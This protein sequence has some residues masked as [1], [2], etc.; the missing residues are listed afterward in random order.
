MALNYVWVA[1]FLIAFAIGL[2]KFLFFGDNEV[3]GL[4]VQS[5]FDMAKV[6]VEIAVYLIGVISL[7][8]G[9]MKVGEQGGAVKLLTKLV[10]PFFKRLFPAVPKD[11]PAVGAMMMN[12]SA[13]MLGLDNA[14]TPLGLK[15]MTELQDLNEDKEKASD[16]MIMFIVLNTSGL[17]VVPVSVMAIRA[18]Q[19]AVNPSDIF[20]PVLLATYF[21]TLGGLV[22]V[23][24]KQ[25]I[26]LLQPVLLSWLVGITAGIAGLLYL[27]NGLE[28]DQINTISNLAGNGI[29][30]GL[31]IGFFSL[32]LFKG[33]NVYETFIE[34]AK[35]GFS[36]S[37]KIIPYLVAMLV[38][39]GL[40]RASGSLDYLVGA[41]GWFFGLFL[42]DV[43]FVDALPTALMKPLSGSGAR[44][45][46]VEQMN[47][48]GADSFVGRLASVFQ[49]STETTF[50]TLA[51]YFG[52]ISIKKTRYA[53]GA[54]LF[55][56]LCGI[57]AAI[58][59]S[60]IFFG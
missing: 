22:A 13:N 34:G 46:M 47:T 33:I 51:V 23:S 36:V 54:G 15:A 44:G 5:T 56:D 20:L 31:I 9:I 19:G 52:A 49:G 39:I 45:M 38:A 53:L 7:W 27:L 28:Q 6:S 43:R 3:F 50:Y 21:S 26:N 14:A 35:D 29:I 4:M 42:E 10:G 12:F 11:H 8:Q 59:I 1:F 58:V 32:A 40:F 55:A 18:A 60:Y 16:A 30:L 48:F 17:T 37:I 24:L 41:I 25:R 57:I 2:V